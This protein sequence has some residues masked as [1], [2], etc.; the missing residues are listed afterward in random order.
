MLLSLALSRLAQSP[1][2]SGADTGSSSSASGS[3]Q[4]DGGA[5][6]TTEKLI[7]PSHPARNSSAV[8]GAIGWPSYL[9]PTGNCVSA[10]TG[11]LPA[12]PPEGPKMLWQRETGSGYSSPVVIDAGLIVQHRMGDEE[13]VEC[14]DPVSGETLW[15]FAYETTYRCP[16]EYSSGPYSTPAISGQ[17]LVTVGAQGQCHCLDMATGELIWRRLLHEDYRV[18]DGLFAVGTSP[19]IDDGRVILC[20]GAEQD[21][22]GIVALDLATGKTLWTATDHGASYATPVTAA[23]H[24][25]RWCF[26]FTAD[27]LVAV[28]PENGTVRWMETFGVGRHPDSANAV[29]PVVW[30]DLVMVSAGPGPGNLCLR[31]LPNGGR[32]T[33]WKNRRA[34]DSQFNRQIVV[35]GFVYGFTSKWNRSASLICVDLRDGSVQW[36]WPSDLMRGSGLWA[37]GRLILLGELGHLALVDD[38]PGADE[39]SVY[40]F[41]AEPLLSAPTYSAPVLYH[42]RLYLRNE[43]RLLCLDFRSP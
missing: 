31:I 1:G 16:Y 4:A 25:L 8:E 11:L 41:T 2:D 22:A 7:A 14:L 15:K 23:I 3:P 40:G 28:D 24:G 21:N 37:D 18:P 13:L 33:I 43:S 29:S 5:E 38:D 10:E 17:R 19:C 36:A 32:E 39:P 35:D 9:G 27:G 30:Q 42:G 12:F 26:V 20:L 34:V 6:H